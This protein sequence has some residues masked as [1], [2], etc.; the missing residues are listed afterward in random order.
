MSNLPHS[1][2]I[3][4]DDPLLQRAIPVHDP[5][6]AFFWNSGADGKLRVMCCGECAHYIHPPSVPCPRCLS[7]DV[8]PAVVSGLG[9]VQACTINVQAWVPGQ[10]PYSVAIIELA[11]QHGLR[12]TSNVIGC[13]PEAV[14]IDQQVRAVFLHR[15]AIYYP[16]FV[17][18]EAH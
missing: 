8:R 9:T 12:L 15:N 14:H 5:L 1:A 11:E 10:H 16:V 17:P 2:S 3:T 18:T 6:S 13:E 7:R 4:V